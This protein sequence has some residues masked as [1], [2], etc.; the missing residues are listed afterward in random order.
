M[1]GCCKICGKVLKPTGHCP[2]CTTIRVGEASALDYVANGL[3]SARDIGPF[4][5]AAVHRRLLGSGIEFGAYVLYACIILPEDVVTGVGGT[6]FLLLVILIVIRDFKSGALSIAKRVGHLRVVDVRT[7]QP[8]SNAQALIR[9]SYY[10]ILSIAAIF[11]WILGIPL[12][13]FFM[14]FILLDVMMILANPR[15]RRFGDFLAGTQVVEA[16]I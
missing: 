10:L 12:M 6:L 15:G 7:G 9:N 16:R 13:F 5:K 1:A 3:P 8:I 11:S 4:P 2:Q 14:M